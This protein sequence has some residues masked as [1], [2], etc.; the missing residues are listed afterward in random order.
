MFKLLQNK[1][2]SRTVLGY[3]VLSCYILTP[4]KYKF[5]LSAFWNLT[6]IVVYASKGVKSGTEVTISSLKF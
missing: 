6:A 3:T 5:N 2:I 1:W 4:V